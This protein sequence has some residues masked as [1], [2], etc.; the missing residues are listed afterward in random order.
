M[1]LNKEIINKI[2]SVDKNLGTIMKYNKQS[3]GRLLKFVLEDLSFLIGKLSGLYEVLL[4]IVPN[5]I[6]NKN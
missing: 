4:E 5:K 2:K 1:I 3:D 6:E